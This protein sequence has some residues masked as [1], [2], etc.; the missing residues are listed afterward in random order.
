MKKPNFLLIIFIVLSILSCS[1]DNDNSNNTPNQVTKFVKKIT[2]PATS[3]TIENITTFNYNANNLLINS[4]YNEGSIGLNYQIS[5]DSNNRITENS[6]EN[7]FGDMS[8]TQFI[9]DSNG[10]LNSVVSPHNNTNYSYNEN[11][12]TITGTVNNLLGV[13]IE[14]ELNSKGKVI[15]SEY[16]QNGLINVFEYDS[17]DNIKTI[18]GILNN[19]TLY[20]ITLEHDN[21]INPFYG[22]Y[23]SIYLDRFIEYFFPTDRVFNDT[24]TRDYFFPFHKNNITSIT[25]NESGVI[26]SKTFTYS[27][28][29]N[30]FINNADVNFIQGSFTESH[31]YNLE[32]YD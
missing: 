7:N 19:Q 16:Y 21:N 29:N 6:S 18:R 24:F 32:Y 9:Y 22:Q 5:Y 12:V 1:T 31:S 25:N 11:F 14:L 8:T 15:S 3:G 17:N 2:K 26:T 20:E 27:Y 13:I 23:E 28:D 30:G 4:Q 10:R